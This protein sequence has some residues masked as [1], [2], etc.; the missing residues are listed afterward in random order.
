MPRS[1][2]SSVMSRTRETSASPTAIIPALLTRMSSRPPCARA[3]PRRP[4]RRPAAV[5][6]PTWPL[7][8]MPSRSS[9]ATRSWIRSVVEAIATWAPPRPSIRAVAKPIPCGLPAPVTRATRRE[10]P[11]A[12]HSP[13]HRLAVAGGVARHPPKPSRSS[14]RACR[15][16]RPAEDLAGRGPFGRRGSAVAFAP[17]SERDRDRSADDALGRGDH[18]THA[19]AGGAAQVEHARPP[20]VIGGAGG[21]RPRSPRGPRMGARPDPSDVDVVA[22]AGPVR[23][24]VVVPKTVSG[25]A[26]AAARRTFGMRWV[27]GSW[28]SP[29][30]SVA[31]ATLK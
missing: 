20:V 5:R 22:D 10:P 7:A 28:S 13:R 3:P 6:S 2:S 24:R 4:S 8:A 21:H 29:F 16:G 30:A 26:P 14:R 31:P 15:S 11:R 17:R 18:L 9:S 19:E 12:T 1:H 27:S 23:R 25:P